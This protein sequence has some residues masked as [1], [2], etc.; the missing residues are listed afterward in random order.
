[1]KQIFLS[2]KF[3]NII[4]VKTNPSLGGGKAPGNEPIYLIA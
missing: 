4:W 3:W 1:M 2:I